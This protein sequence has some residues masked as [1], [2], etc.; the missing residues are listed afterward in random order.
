VLTAAAVLWSGL[1]G[2]WSPWDADT[3]WLPLGPA[4][5]VAVSLVGGALV[6]ALTILGTRVLV[7]RGG[8]ARTLHSNFRALLGPLSGLEIAAYAVL[9]GV[10]EELF[11]RGAMQPALGLGLTSLIFGAVHFGPTRSFWVWTVWAGAMGLVFGTLVAL[12]GNLYGAVLAHLVINYENLHFID[13]YDP[14]ASSLEERLGG[15]AADASAP[16]KLSGTRV[17]TGR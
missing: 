10:A 3:A 11:F 1:R 17:R 13:A 16:P 7:R 2:D 12:T 8:W 9:S 5:R 15:G 6:A 4:A 14:S